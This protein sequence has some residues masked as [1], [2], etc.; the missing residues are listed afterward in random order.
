M[1]NTVVQNFAANV[2]LATGSSP[3]MSMNGKEAGDLA[4]LGG[5]LVINMGT[6][7]SDTLDAYVAGMKA[8]NEAGNPVLLDPVGG[9]AT[10]LRRQTIQT[11]LRAGFFS[12]IKGNEG[13]IGAVAGTTDVQQRGVD[14]GP[15]FSTAAQKIAMVRSLAETQRCVVLMTGATDYLSDGDRTLSISNGSHWLGRITGSGCALGS[16][17]A[18]YVALHRSDKLVATVAALLHYE[19]AAER[20]EKLCH[21][22]GSFIPAFL[23]QL[24]LLGTEIRDGKYDNI[25]YDA[26]IEWL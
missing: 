24:Y 12:V 19:I 3:I 9:G 14:S 1:T 18:S 15:S 11:L 22:P 10:S 7:T 17:I 6:V 23:D 8:Y 16:V 13:E 21:G 25:G 2:C 20:A 26:R 4:K 5:A